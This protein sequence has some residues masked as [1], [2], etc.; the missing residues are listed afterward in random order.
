MVARS[1]GRLCIRYSATPVCIFLDF[2]LPRG[3]LDRARKVSARAGYWCL[4]S[5]LVGAVY[6]GCY[7]FRMRET[8]NRLL[9]SWW[10]T[11][12][13]PDGSEIVTTDLLVVREEN[14]AFDDRLRDEEAIERIAVV[15]G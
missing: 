10:P 9:H 8:P 5:H 1:W 12:D 15:R 3:R 11:L 2:R 14:N 6:L 4:S 13:E 7:R